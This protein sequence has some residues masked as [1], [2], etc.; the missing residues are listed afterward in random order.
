MGQPYNSRGLALVYVQSL[1]MAQHYPIKRSF[2]IC[3][4]IRQAPIVVSSS[5]YSVL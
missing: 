2:V 1:C 4:R 3:V 5:P